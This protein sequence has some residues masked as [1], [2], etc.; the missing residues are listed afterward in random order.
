M[1]RHHGPHLPLGRRRGAAL[2][3]AGLQVPLPAD[4]GDGAIPIIAGIPGMTNQAA[5]KI[6]AM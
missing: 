2:R 4:G 3:G 1:G 5:K 6:V